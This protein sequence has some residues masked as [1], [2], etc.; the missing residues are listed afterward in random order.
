VL[1]TY[2][3][4]NQ[5]KIIIKIRIEEVFSSHKKSVNHSLFEKYKLLTEFIWEEY[6]Q[7]KPTVFDT[8]FF[9][10]VDNEVHVVN[11]LRT[12][13]KTLDIAIF[14]LTNDKITAAINEAFNRGVKVRIIAD[15]ECCKML[16]SDVFRLAL[17]VSRNVYL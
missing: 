3:S 2:Q 17:Q 11:M 7:P 6:Y 9:P 16:G 10:N 12:C 13:K 15:D 1:T 14:T 4:L 5:C 8:Y